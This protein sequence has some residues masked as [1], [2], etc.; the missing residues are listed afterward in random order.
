MLT[1]SEVAQIVDVIKGQT[2]YDL[3]NIKIFPVE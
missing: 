2:E 3:D 1:A